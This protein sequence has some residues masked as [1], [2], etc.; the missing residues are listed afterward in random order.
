MRS[1]LDP[2]VASEWHDYYR[3]ADRRRR[4]RGWHRRRDSKP[5]K[6]KGLDAGKALAIVMGL[7]TVVVVLCLVLPA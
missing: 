1:K 5:P 7:A 6:R 2:L 4:E 3:A